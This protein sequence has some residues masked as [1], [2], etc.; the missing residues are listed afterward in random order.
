MEKETK[1]LKI[2]LQ[3]LT[4]EIISLK[5]VCSR[6]ADAIERNNKVLT[7]GKEVMLNDKQVTM[8]CTAILRG[9]NNIMLE[10]KKKE[11]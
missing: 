10:L 4:E 11:G 7:I 5:Y 6:L 3:E 8:L 2:L 1:P 9:L